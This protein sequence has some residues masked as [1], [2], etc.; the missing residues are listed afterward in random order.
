[1]ELKLNRR[2]AFGVTTLV[3]TSLRSSQA[4]PASCS[5]AGNEVKGNTLSPDGNPSFLAVVENCSANTLNSNH[6]IK[7]SCNKFANQATGNSTSSSYTDRSFCQPPK[8]LKKDHHF[9]TNSA[10]SDFSYADKSNCLKLNLRYVKTSWQ[11]LYL[12]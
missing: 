2:A 3:L 6:Q 11:Y 12:S 10:V 5:S 4:S 8:R 1:M 7:S 9:N